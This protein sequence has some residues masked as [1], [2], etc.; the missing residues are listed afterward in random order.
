MNL[1]EPYAQKGIAVIVLAIVLAWLIFFTEYLPFSY[2]STAAELDTLKD[3]LQRVAGE[4]QRLESAANRLPQIQQ[5]LA[6]L[7]R[8]WEV[9]RDLLPRETEMSDLLSDVTTAGLKAGVQFS[10]F[11][12]GA[13]EPYDLYVRY[14]IQVSVTGGY[15]QVGRFL[16]NLCNMDRLVDIS[17]L[18]LSQISDGAEVITVEASAVIS[19]YTYTEPTEPTEQSTEDQVTKAPPKPKE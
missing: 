5:E 9:L 14:P 18:N 13:A 16:D 12:P 6:T 4:L 11:E 19:A 1:R 3:E 17:N 2:R 7:V 15:H 10:L 8:K